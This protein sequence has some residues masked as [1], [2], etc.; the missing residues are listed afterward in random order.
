MNEVLEHKISTE[1]KYGFVTDIEADNA[2]KEQR[3]GAK[4]KYYKT[5]NNGKTK[6]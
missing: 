1:Y 4:V 5:R 2:P 3:C 6:R